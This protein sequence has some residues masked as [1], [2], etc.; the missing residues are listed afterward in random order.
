LALSLEQGLPAVIHS[1]GYFEELIRI[2][3]RFPQLKVVFHCFSYAQPELTAVLE[4]GYYVSFALNI[5]K[6]NSLDEC[7]KAVPPD[8]LLLETDCPYMY[9]NKKE[10]NPLH[11]KNMAERAAFL[12][13]VPPEA[14]WAGLVK[15]AAKAFNLEKELL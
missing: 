14:L 8:K 9:F 4:R 15:N 13:G 2:L 6:N 7:L 11:I 12:R 10:S 5:F 1:R 3:D